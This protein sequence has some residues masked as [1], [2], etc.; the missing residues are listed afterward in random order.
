MDTIFTAYVFPNG[1]N[2]TPVN[3]S[4]D[5]IT[6]DDVLDNAVSPIWDNAPFR[7]FRLDFDVETGALEAGTE[8][9]ERALE[10]LQDRSA[11]RGF[12]LPAWMINAMRRAA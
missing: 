1:L 7:M 2:G 6:F 4:D 12:D 8:V 10:V 3:V 9:T 11:E 5:K